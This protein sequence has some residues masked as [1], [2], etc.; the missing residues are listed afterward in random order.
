MAAREAAALGEALGLAE[1]S[2]QPIPD[3]QVAE[4]VVVDTQLVMDGVVLGI[5][6]LFL[7]VL[8]IWIW[9]AAKR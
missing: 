4:V 9:R 7:M 8:P 2:K 1:G 5:F 3:R 6:G